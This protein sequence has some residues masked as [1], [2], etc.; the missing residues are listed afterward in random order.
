M[1]ATFIVMSVR[2]AGRCVDSSHSFWGHVRRHVLL[3]LQRHRFFRPVCLGRLP[4]AHYRP[5]NDSHFSRSAPLWRT[6][7]MTHVS[8]QTKNLNEFFSIVRMAE[9]PR[10]RNAK[11]HFQIRFS[12]DRLTFEWKRFA[13]IAGSRREKTKKKERKKRLFFIQSEF[14]FFPWLASTASCLANCKFANMRHLAKWIFRLRVRAASI[15]HCRKPGTAN[16]QE[17][18]RRNF[19]LCVTRNNERENANKVLIKISFWAR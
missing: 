2:P 13:R 6:S 4:S 5:P 11:H 7:E 14:S 10:P 3:F 1:R 9:T 19:I 18:D 8:V 16:G 17:C 12:S 15:E